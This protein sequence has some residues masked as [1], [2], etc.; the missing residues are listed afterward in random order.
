LPP[1][2]ALR[3]LRLSPVSVCLLML[4]T[5]LYCRLQRCDVVGC[6]GKGLLDVEPSRRQNSIESNDQPHTTGALRKNLGS[7]RPG[8]RMSSARESKASQAAV[9][10]VPLCSVR[11]F[12]IQMRMS[13]ASFLSLDVCSC[14]QF[15]S[16]VLM[17]LER[18]LE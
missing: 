16:R 3:W 6:S 11:I 17:D 18:P 9:Y 14:V 4:E 10:V 15:P 1:R 2:S 13:H 7:I 12:C 8:S 5:E